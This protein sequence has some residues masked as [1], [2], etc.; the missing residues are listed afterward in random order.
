MDWFI[1]LTSGTG[2]GALLYYGIR[3]RDSYV[4]CIGL[5]VGSIW[6]TYS[7]GRQVERQECA[8]VGRGE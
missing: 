2:G 4:F 5:L 3:D 1:A 7:I 8:E 6:P